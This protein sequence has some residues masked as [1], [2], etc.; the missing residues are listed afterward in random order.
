MF[1]SGI[2]NGFFSLVEFAA[3]IFGLLVVNQTLNSDLVFSGFA[4]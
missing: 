4:R 3:P 1:A 2:F